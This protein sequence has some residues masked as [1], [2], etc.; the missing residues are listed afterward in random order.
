M[1]VF[2][3]KVPCQCVQHIF[4]FKK[5]PKY[6]SILRAYLFF[7]AKTLLLF[8][9]RSFSPLRFFSHPDSTVGSGI[10]PDHALR[11]AGFTAGR[12]SHP[13]LK[14]IYSASIHIPN[15]H[16][17]TPNIAHPISSVNSIR[18]ISV[19]I[20]SRSASESNCRTSYLTFTPGFC[21]FFPN[22]FA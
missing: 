2:P 15:A 1:P 4:R 14:I 11:L 16:S 7:C 6:P 12:E 13:A 10:S 19:T 8:Y 22:S 20:H 17:T 5:S 18:L 21:P 9:S 3:A